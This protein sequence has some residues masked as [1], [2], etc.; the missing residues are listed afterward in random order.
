MFQ[1]GVERRRKMTKEELAEIK[2]RYNT[3]D[4]SLM[5]MYVNT[6]QIF[7]DVPKLLAEVERLQK[8]Q[9]RNLSVMGSLLTQLDRHEPS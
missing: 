8:E 1:E 9:E 4:V 5:Y 6:G 2:A 3:Q 7:E